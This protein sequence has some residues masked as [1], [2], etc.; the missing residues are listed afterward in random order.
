MMMTIAAIMATLP[1]AIV[2]GASSEV[3]R[4]LGIAVVGGLLFSLLLTL[5]ITP[6]FYLYMDS[7]PPRLKKQSHFKTQIAMWFREEP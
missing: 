3:R 4:P 5:Y 6:V 1:I 2:M 7:F